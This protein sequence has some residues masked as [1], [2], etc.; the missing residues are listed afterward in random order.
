VLN[1]AGLVE[2]PLLI[3]TA[4]AATSLGLLVPILKDADAVVRPVGQLT[5][6]GASAGE[7]STVLLLSLFF[8]EHASGPASRVLLL[9]GLT[10]LTALIAVTSIRAGRTMWLPEA[11]MN[12]ADTSTQVRGPPLRAP[13][14]GPWRGPPSG[15][16]PR[17]FGDVF[18]AA[19]ARPQHDA[20]PQGHIRR[21]VPIRRQRPQ[22]LCLF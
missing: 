2:S 19:L 14:T 15:R 18:A 21:H 4:L 10:C 6:G 9:L 5:I 16:T 13:R 17:Q 8:S 1:L 20:G 22:F 7:I 11:V 3:G 12:L